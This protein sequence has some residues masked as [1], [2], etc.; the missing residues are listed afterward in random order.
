MAELLTSTSLIAFL[1]LAALEIVLGI[2]NVVF[3][4][5]LADKLPEERRRSGRIT[6]LMLAAL[7]RILLLLG[8]TWIIR[9]DESELF[10]VF[11]RHVTVRGLILM[12]GGAFL[13]GKATWEIHESLEGPHHHGAPTAGKAGFAAV[14]F[15][16]LMMDLIFS[17]DS[18]LTAIG[19]VK[20]DS[21]EAQ[22][23]PLVVMIAAIV[24]AIVVMLAFAGPLSRFIQKH[25]T[26]KMLA[27]SF[28]LL[29]GVV[30][31][32]EGLHVTL[33]RGYIYFAMGFSLFV[34]LLNLK[35]WSHRRKQRA[36][37]T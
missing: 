9:M 17:I 7:G 15:Q 32:A 35:I 14:I 23:V 11:G 6:G 26:M 33:P 2:D 3:I 8:I 34:E 19:M 10:T 20:P 21:Y 13:L 24:V 27:L 16:I 36:A 4:A 29:I 1:T 31:M 28:L 30:L 5:I 37:A 12:L 18:V 25:P 22:W